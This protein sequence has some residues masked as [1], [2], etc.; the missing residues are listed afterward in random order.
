[1]IFLDSSFLISFFAG[2]DRHHEKAIK[3]AEK[4]ENKEK[5]IS[6]LVI[7]EVITILRL[8]LK[9]KQVLEIYSNLPENFT[10]IEDQKY[11]NN[12]MNE[13]LK[14]NGNIS[15]FDSMYLYLMKKKGIHEIASF[16]EDFDNKY[17][18]IRIH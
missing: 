11:Y 1:M 4:I 15:F 13:F 10:I 6:K 5:I 7:A 9:A 8:K 16:D 3:I 14:Y 17:G 18:I 2:K 12:A